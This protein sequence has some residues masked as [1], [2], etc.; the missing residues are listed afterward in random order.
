[1]TDVFKILTLNNIAVEGLRRF[2]REHYEVG[3]DLAHPDAILVRSHSMHDMQM[4]EGLLAVARAGAG[5]NN[6]PVDQM[7]ASGIPVFNAPGANANAV[8]E[9]VLGGLLL[10]ARNLASAWDYVRKLQGDEGEVARAVE[11]G[12]KRF[13]GFELPGRTLGVIGLGAIGVEVANAALELGMHVIGYDPQITVRRAWQLSSGV[14][15]AATLDDVFSR[16]D[17]ITVHVPL[18]D[19]TRGMIDKRR[20][21]LLPRGA[22]VLNFARA[23]IVD[24]QAM[25]QLLDADAIHTYVTDFPTPA[26]KDHP[27]VVCLPHLGASTR[28]AE[29]N[30]AIMVADNL[31]EFL[32][33]GNIRH[34]V[35][36]PEAVLRR[37]RPH[38]LA[39]ANAN[40][41]NMVGQ[42]STVL[43]EENLNIADLLNVS[44]GE[45][46]YTIVDLDGPASAETLKLILSIDGILSS[47][48][49]P[50]YESISQDA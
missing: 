33:N 27:R 48:A 12:K 24:D 40:V 11:A 47:R 32:E 35:N 45:V 34:S 13:V 16:A 46:A 1:M 2:P 31:K 29:E 20:L 19:D 26:L 37:T 14:K 10:A 28:E 21:R 15:Q 50:I 8:K 22:I 41:P 30:C 25:I 3:S 36:F 49:L 39:I 18:N 5:V 4:P 42:V 9:L 44:R 6:I 7:S 23:G 17:A 38:R 43:A